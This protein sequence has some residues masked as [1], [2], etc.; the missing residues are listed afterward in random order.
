MIQGNC[1]L[2]RL[3]YGNVSKTL[4]QFTESFV[5]LERG[6]KTCNVVFQSQG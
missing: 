3:Y 1:A 4:F 6:T 2:Q 5:F